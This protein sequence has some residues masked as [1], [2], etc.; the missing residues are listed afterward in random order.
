MSQLSICIPSKNRS[1]VEVEGR[2]LNLLPKC[3]A[4]LRAAWR[5]GD[6]WQIVV[7]DF[8]SDDWPLNDWIDDAAA[9]IPVKVMAI[10][11][12]FSAG[13]GLNV[14]ATHAT[15]ENLLF[16]GADMLVDRATMVA[17]L[18]HLRNSV[19]YVPMPMVAMDPEHK[20]LQ[21]GTLA[22]GTMFITHTLFGRVGDFPEFRSH[23]LCDTVWVE[24]GEALNMLR[25]LECQPGLIHQWHPYTEEF[26]NR[27]YPDWRSDN[28][29]K[30]AA[31]KAG[32][33]KESLAWPM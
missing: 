29:K 17:G 13:K 6:D 23:G 31:W 22:V 11:G 32:K 30:L 19:I 4:S 2:I 3:I 12:P 10:E 1:R 26:M 15:H 9:P 33:F 20:D 7:A 5:E 18:R 8:Q 21:F 25:R 28:D 14:A 27:H 16:L 24:R